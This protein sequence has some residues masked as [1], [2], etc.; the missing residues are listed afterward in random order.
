MQVEDW[1]TDHPD[2]LEH[3]EARVTSQNGEDGILR[4]IFEKIGTTDQIFIEVGSG[5]GSENITRELQRHGWSGFWIEADPVKAATARSLDLRRVDVIEAVAHPEN[6]GGI[7]GA[8]GA[9]NDIDLISVDI[10]GDDYRVLKALLAAVRPRVVVVEYNAAFGPNESWVLPARATTRGWDETY[11]HGASLRSLAD[12]CTR[13][14]LDLVTCDSAGVNAFF[15]RRELCAPFPAP[16][17]VRA[18]YRPPTH[19]PLL[20]GHPRSPRSVGLELR[21]VQLAVNASPDWSKLPGANSTVSITRSG[22]GATMTDTAKLADTLL[23]SAAGSTT[24]LLA[25]VR[26]IKK[27][28][29]SGTVSGIANVSV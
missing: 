29:P 1:R 11:R 7:L 5:D 26:T 6:I 24:S 28:A 2:G 18:H 8:A 4:A 19:S 10:D 23:P 15:V 17:D 12:L 21:P 22:S 27:Y 9:P 14:G 20:G 13:N 16:G 3:S 25:S